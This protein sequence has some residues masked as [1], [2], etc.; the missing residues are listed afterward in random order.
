MFNVP[1]PRSYPSLQ[2]VHNVAMYFKI[3]VQLERKLLMDSWFLDDNN[4]PRP[5]VRDG[6]IRILQLDPPNKTH[7]ALG[8]LGAQRRQLL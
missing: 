7:P 5:G 4:I 1:L 6:T 2:Y 8:F 3:N